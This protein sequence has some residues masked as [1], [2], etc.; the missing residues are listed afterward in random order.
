[1]N[2]GMRRPGLSRCSLSL[3]VVVVAVTAVL[4]AQQQPPTTVNVNAR[5]AQPTITL[6][7]PNSGLVGDTI[8]LTGSGFGAVQGSGTVTFNGV[9]AVI[10]SWSSLSITVTVPSTTT[11]NVVV[12]Q[13]GLTSVGVSFTVN[14]ASANP[15]SAA[16]LPGGDATV[17][18]P[19]W[20]GVGVV[21]GIP[22]SGWSNCVTAQCNTVNSGTVTTASLEAAITSAPNNTVVRVPAGTFTMANGFMINRGGVAVRGAGA[23]STI[24]RPTGISA[25]G[26]GPGGIGRVINLGACSG[27]NV[28][29]V[30]P[31]HTAT[32]TPVGASGSWT[33]TAGITQI[34][35]SSTTGLFVGDT[36]FLDQTNDPST[37]WPGTGDIAVCAG[38]GTCQNSGG[39]QWER[40]GRELVEGHLVT[41]I[42]GTTVTLQ[43]GLAMPS[44]RSSQTPGAWWGNSGS[45]S[46]FSGIE[47]L[48]IDMRGSTASGIMAGPNCYNCWV[49][50]VRIVQPQNA[51]NAYLIVTIQCVHCTFEQ[52]Y[53]FGPPTQELVNTYGYAL[54]VCSFCL[55]QNNILHSNSAPLVPN[56]SIYGN[57]VAYNFIDEG[58]GASDVEHGINGMQLVEGNDWSNY[59]GDI[60]HGPH[61]FLTAFRNSMSGTRYNSNQS[62]T[63]AGVALYARNRFVNIVG[64][65]FNGP[66][67]STY[68]RDC[69]IATTC[70]STGGTQCTSCIYLFGW[71]G[72]SQN[73]VGNDTNVARTAMRWCNWDIVTSTGDTASNDQTGI[74]CLA[75]EV[76]SGIT[77]FPNAVPGSTALPASLYLSAKPAFVGSLPWPMTG[78]DV[79]GGDETTA[80]GHA[81]KN[82]AH[83]CFDAAGTDSSFTTTPAVKLNTGSACP[84]P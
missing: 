2:L 40:S 16:R 84:V 15:I 63:E 80:G 20:A 23:T 39:S 14:S 34:T 82:P 72:T 79:S 10:T 7:N 65:V 81:Y 17:P 52:N 21:G 67:W 28:G 62:E 77:N 37:G 71:Q 74:K 83:R 44:F 68:F 54:H 6:V 13:S 4:L 61:H 76:P 33:A 49:K 58:L 5:P 43:E 47:N 59:S 57:V 29:S 31:D 18:N 75:S 27:T 11:G 56:D 1:M 45:V 22:S 64:N 3:A 41:A 48:T 9:S 30:N 78:P 26:C 73:P 70:D 25:Q 60:I 19:I 53:L 50:G 35:L 42:N 69:A 32:W 55:V 36:L 66:N 51:T 8:T 38:D 46:S 12:S 24:L